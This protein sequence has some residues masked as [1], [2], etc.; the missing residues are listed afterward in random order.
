MDHVRDSIEVDIRH[1]IDRVGSLTTLPIT[2]FDTEDRVA[3]LKDRLAEGRRG[4]RGWGVTVGG[5][6]GG[7]H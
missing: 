6:P 2:T 3:L 1:A 4:A 5:F 7:P